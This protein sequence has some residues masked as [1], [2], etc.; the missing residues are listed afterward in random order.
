MKTIE[1]IAKNH[2]EKKI[3]LDKNHTYEKSF[4]HIKHNFYKKQ[5]QKINEFN[6]DVNLLDCDNNNIPKIIN[7][8]CK[9]KK[10]ITNPI[11]NECLNKIKGMYHDYKIF[12]YD[13]HDIYKIIELFDKKNLDFIKKIVIG[14]TLADIFRYLILYLR[15]GYYFDMDCQPIKHINQLSNLHFHGD[16][17]NKFYICSKNKKIINS[18]CEFHENPCNNYN[19]ININN[20]KNTFHCLGHKYITKNTNIITGYE[21]D[22]TWNKN[23]ID[24]HLEKHKWVDNNIGICQWFIASK[25]T[26]SLFLHCYKNSLNN[27][28]KLELN[29]NNSEYHFQVINGTGPLFFTKIINKFIKENESFKNNIAVFPTDFF[30]C[31]SGGTVPQTKNTFVKHMFTG[32]WLK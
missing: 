6:K 1:V 29:K 23:I 19:V 21:F 14:A 22:A 7:L 16:D 20:E 25:P 32:T 12:I 24:N 3:I 4:R 15:G 18:S 28:K 17:N 31:G 27:L 13:N 2:F 5:I 30:C 9:D 11:W 8:T 26:Q 10:N